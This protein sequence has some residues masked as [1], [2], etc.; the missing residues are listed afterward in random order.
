MVRNQ[1]TA[2]YLATPIG[3]AIWQAK[4]RRSDSTG[5]PDL[6]IEDTWPAFSMR[7]RKAR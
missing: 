1:D 6:A 3:A 5:A 7:S 2:G 4:Y